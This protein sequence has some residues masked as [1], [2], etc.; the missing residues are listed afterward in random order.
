[1]E[2]ADTSQP[3]VAA[4]AWAET[5][6]LLSDV[7]LF[8]TGLLDHQEGA[9]E[10]AEQVARGLS[11]HFSAWYA[12]KAR[13]EGATLSVAVMALT[14]SGERSCGGRGAVCRLSGAGWIGECGKAA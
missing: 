6:S 2:D 7:G 4:G 3:G 10:V 12:L 5:Q 9:E 13:A 11:Q 1:M 14:K 8:L